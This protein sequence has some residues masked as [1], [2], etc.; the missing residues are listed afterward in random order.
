MIGVINYRLTDV[1]HRR[2]PGRRWSDQI[3]RP[4]EIIS[5]DGR[6]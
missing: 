1:R 3:G 4:T 6:S 2:R 5:G